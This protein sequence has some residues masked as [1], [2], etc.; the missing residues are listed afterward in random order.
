MQHISATSL[1]TSL[2]SRIAYLSSFLNLTPSDTDALLAA[3]PLLAPLIPSI[4]DAVYAKLLSYDITAQVFVPKNTDYEGEVVGSVQELTLEHPQIALRKDFLKV[5]L[6]LFRGCAWFGFWIWILDFLKSR[7]HN[8]LIRLV[9][10]PDLTPT[11][12]FWTCLNNVGIMHTG[13]PGFKHRASKPEL[14]VEYMHMGALLGYVEDIVVG[15]V[16]GMEGVDAGTKMRVM[17]A[18]NKVLWIQND[19]FAR[20]YLAEEG[21][22]SKAA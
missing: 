2:P 12:P 4:L 13:R 15:V 5:C 20:H 21:G 8:Y 9:S 3:K 6:C 16:M 22:M 19:L 17:R 11:S 1:T 14:R 7:L 10:T 18:F